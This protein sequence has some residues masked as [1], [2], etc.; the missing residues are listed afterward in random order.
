M[1]DLIV[2][3]HGPGLGLDCYMIKGGS[4]KNK[5]PKGIKKIQMEIC[6]KIK[7]C[8]CRRQFVLG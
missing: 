5:K 7:H 8:A 1:I 3:D 6:S 2:P 4:G